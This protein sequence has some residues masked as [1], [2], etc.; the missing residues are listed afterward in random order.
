MVATLTD[1]DSFLYRVQALTWVH[2]KCIRATLAR[3]GWGSD[4]P[5]VIQSE[6][7]VEYGDAGDAPAIGA[8]VRLTLDVL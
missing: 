1:S 7:T 3:V 2:H 6:V 4:V 8:L 5:G